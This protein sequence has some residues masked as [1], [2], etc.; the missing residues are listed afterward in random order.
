MDLEFHLTRKKDLNCLNKQRNWEAQQEWPI[1]V[2][3][4]SMVLELQKTEIEALSFFLNLHKRE[5]NMLKQS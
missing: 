4:F 3:A 5:T 2:N 1:L